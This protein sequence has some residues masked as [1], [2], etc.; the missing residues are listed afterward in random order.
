MSLVQVR[1]LPMLKIPC[2]FLMA[3]AVV[4]G[5]ALHHAHEITPVNLSSRVFVNRCW[6]PG[7]TEALPCSMALRI[8]LSS[9]CHRSQF[10]DCLRYVDIRC[11]VATSE[12]S[13]ATADEWVHEPILRQ[14][15]VNQVRE[16]GVPVQ[17][18]IRWP[19]F[20]PWS[21]PTRWIIG[22]HIHKQAGS[23]LGTGVNLV[24]APSPRCP[25]FDNHFNDCRVSVMILAPLAQI[26]DRAVCHS[27]FAVLGG[28]WQTCRW[29]SSLASHLGVWTTWDRYAI[30]LESFGYNKIHARQ[31]W[32]V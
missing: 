4:I 18:T 20:L 21:I 7:R 28:H 26:V 31:R 3:L 9:A 6:C 25:A 32:H 11:D 22:H 16:G 5:L 8:W 12:K 1:T 15:I 23:D 17:V 10:E 2:R 19:D 24:S 13:A 27:I 29:S 14:F 30:G